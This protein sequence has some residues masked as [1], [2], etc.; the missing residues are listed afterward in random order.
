MWRR[1]GNST[2]S[3]CKPHI[4]HCNYSKLLNPFTNCL[5]QS[6]WQKC[7]SI[8]LGPLPQKTLYLDSPIKI[9]PQV[10]V[11]SPCLLAQVGEYFTSFLV[12]VSGNGWLEILRNFCSEINSAEFFYEVG[13][14]VDFSHFSSAHGC[15]ANG[16]LQISG[17][18]IKKA[19]VLTVASSF[20]LAER[21]G[22]EPPVHVSIHTLSRRAPSATR[23]PLRNQLIQ[24]KID[25]F[26]LCVKA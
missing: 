2:L 20:L 5:F 4:G 21:G 23:S 25:S 22:F 13:V 7:I 11:H 10:K 6:A 26:S 15:M 8:P 19:T 9:K 18:S 3:N 12:M 1:G 14:G 16:G 17:F 24:G